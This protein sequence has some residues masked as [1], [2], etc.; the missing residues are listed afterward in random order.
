M[1]FRRRT[2]RVRIFERLIRNLILRIYAAHTHIA[3]YHR[4]IRL[5]AA[6]NSRMMSAILN[7]HFYYI[8]VDIARRLIT[9]HTAPFLQD[10]GILHA[11]EGER[12]KGAQTRLLFLNLV[13]RLRL[14]RLHSLYED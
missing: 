10:E 2:D 8:N 12:E 5:D 9:R 3:F 13:S 14:R 1:S 4:S 7:S 6:A 11:R